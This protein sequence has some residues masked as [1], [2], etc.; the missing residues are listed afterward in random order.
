MNKFESDYDIIV[1]GAGAAGL[2][3][4]ARAAERG[5]K[6]LLIE[7]MEKVGKK[8]A[9]TGKGRCN[10][11]NDSPISLHLKH[12]K[13]QARFLRFA[14]S[15][16]FTN[17]IINLLEKY[18]VKTIVERGSRVFPVSNSSADVVNALLKHCQ[19][20]GVKILLNSEVTSILCNNNKVEGVCFT[21]LGNT[22]NIN[23]DNVIIC[24]GGKSYPA[25][26]S[27]GD[28]Y[29]F[30]KSAGHTISPVFPALV[31][32]ETEGTIA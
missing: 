27:T 6:V 22:L 10:I 14:Y 25:M 7:K 12:I 5:K 29:V 11:T 15:S 9:I 16:F 4:A 20:H 31:P 8:L 24:T 13:P 19:R 28:G 1:V 21:H 23:V 17:D 30:A 26:G 3:S 32:I 2:L 18:G